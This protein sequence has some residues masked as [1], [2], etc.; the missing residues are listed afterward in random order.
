[1]TR[2]SLGYVALEWTCPK[3]GS[4]NPGPVKTCA[5]CGAPQPEDVQFEQVEGQEL[6]ADEQEIQRAKIGPDIHCAFCGARNSADAEVCTQCGA[7]LKEGV[8]R[9]AGRVIGAYKS[10]P[11]KRVACP[12]CG[13]ENPETSLKC[14]N[15]GAPLTL[16]KAPT[17]VGRP[18]PL[19]AAPTRKPGWMGIAVVG[20]LFVLCVCAVGAFIFLSSPR[21]SQVGAV[22]AVEW[23]TSVVV[24]ALQPVSYETWRSEI[25]PGS[26]IGS[27]VE[28]VHH[29]QDEAPFGANSNKVCGTPYTVDTGTG[30][31]EVVQD[32]QF[33]VLLPYCEYTVDEWRTLD[34]VS[35]SGGDLMPVWPEPPVLSSQRLGDREGNYVVV[36]ATPD[37][38]YTYTVSSV[39]Q[40][41]QFAIGSEWILNINGLGQLVSV[42]P[43]G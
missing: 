31:G 9:E 15:C 16:E 33:E 19:Q 7:D 10:Q 28:R 17:Q 13:V 23:Q 25:P 42:E 2:E 38:Q 8:R 37:G 32:C 6:V 11:V 41:R 26:R 39:E 4:R 1:M 34:V 18:S 40:F 29:L 36:F 30:L 5:N 20:L 21:E 22:Q 24:E 14:S 3:C 43:A 35:L 27:C 12:N